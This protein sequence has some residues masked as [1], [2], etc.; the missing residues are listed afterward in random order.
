MGMLNMKTQFF[1]LIL[2][3]SIVVNDAFRTI[4]KYLIVSPVRVSRY[5]ILRSTPGSSTPSETED[6]K[7]DSE[8]II[9]KKLDKEIAGVALPAFFSL[10]ADPLASLVDAMYVG[11]LTA[12]DQVYEHS[13]FPSLTNKL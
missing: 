7:D 13:C 10:A 6:T 12:A 3:L 9:C 2:G 4:P 5:Q 1:F 11:R 8:E